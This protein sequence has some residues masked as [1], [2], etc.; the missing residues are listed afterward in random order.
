[1]PEGTCKK[2]GKKYCGWALQQPQY[3]V[4]GCGG[5]IEV[6]TVPLYEVAKCNK[7]G[8]TYDDKESVEL[9]KKFKS[10]GDGYAP[11]PNISCDGQ[12]E[13]FKDSAKLTHAS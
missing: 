13:V 10:T 11:C 4:C 1:M 8:A 3:R 2:C 9:V 7:C 6:T 5:E 12:M